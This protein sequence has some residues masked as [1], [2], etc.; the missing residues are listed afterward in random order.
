MIE[1][2]K[3][4]Y[5]MYSSLERL[6]SLDKHYYKNPSYSK[7][8]QRLKN[9]VDIINSNKYL[10]FDSC[11]KDFYKYEIRGLEDDVF[12]LTDFMYSRVGL[13]DV[14]TC[15]RYQDSFRKKT[16]RL[17]KRISNIL[18]EDHLFFLTFTFDN[19]KFRNKNLPKQETLRKYVSRW[20]Q[21]Y[22]NDYVGNVDFGEQFGRIHFHCV[23]S[24]KQEKVNPTTWKK[25]AI[26]FQRINNKNDKA[27]ALYVNK[28]CSHA[29]KESTKNQ[30]LLYPK[31]TF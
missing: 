13:L 10:W 15:Y 22:T 9:R 1:I 30:Y 2:E 20:L 26:N 14:L 5:N 7:R 23:V 18:A 6:E 28:L 24:L 11:S 12:K 25:G 31:R 27:L 16:S 3:D 17:R 4:L 8:K 19:D 21:E 29:L